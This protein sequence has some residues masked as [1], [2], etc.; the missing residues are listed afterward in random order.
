[1]KALSLSR[2]VYYLSS[3]DFIEILTMQSPVPECSESEDEEVD[4]DPLLTAFRNDSGTVS[5]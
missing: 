1:M 2:K 5:S 3:D 4:N